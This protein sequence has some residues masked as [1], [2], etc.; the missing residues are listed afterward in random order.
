MNRTELFDLHNLLT[1]KAYD[2]MKAKNADYATDADVLCNLSQ[3]ER[4]GV[5]STETAIASRFLDK[6]TRL[7]NL[8]LTP[9]KEAHVTDEA[10]DDTVCD[11]INYLVL[12]YVAYH[13]RLR[14]LDEHNVAH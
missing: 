8:T 11:A 2:I 3:S 12:W 14:L 5:C 7:T 4:A 1:S 13:R 10:I 9:G 6:F